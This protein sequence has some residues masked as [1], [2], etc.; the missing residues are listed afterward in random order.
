ML[1][2]EPCVYRLTF[3]PS[4]AVVY[5]GETDNARRRA[6]NYRTPGASQQTSV[7]INRKLVEHLTQRGAVD[8]AIVTS[9]QMW[10]NADDPE[11]LD[12]SSKAA[13]LLVENAALVAHQFA[14]G[15][16]VLNL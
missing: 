16:E 7:R 14:D 6:G 8:L 11:Q 3:R 15:C 5:F 4:P 13:R 2:S 10:R 1:A 9:A 12:L